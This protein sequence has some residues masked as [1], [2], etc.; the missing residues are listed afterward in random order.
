LGDHHLRDRAFVG[1][2]LFAF[3]YV[4]Q[5]WYGN[6][7]HDDAVRLHELTYYFAVASAALFVIG[8]IVAARSVPWDP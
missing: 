5:L 7:R 2:A 6:K 1:V 4:V 3:A 8:M